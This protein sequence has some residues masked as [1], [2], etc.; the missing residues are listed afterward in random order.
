[1]SVQCSDGSSCSQGQ[2][3]AVSVTKIDGERLK[4]S[5]T[6][7]LRYVSEGRWPSVRALSRAYRVSSM[8]MSS[9][10]HSKACWHRGS[11]ATIAVSVSTSPAL[12]PCALLRIGQHMAPQ[13]TETD[14]L[15][16]VVLR[17][18]DR[19]PVHRTPVFDSCAVQLADKEDQLPL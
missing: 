9:A 7:C 4:A 18:P 15:A 1:M 10:W 6:T 3:K 13:C 11:T 17:G 8:A 12:S 19:A 14:K 5:M 16:R 2:H